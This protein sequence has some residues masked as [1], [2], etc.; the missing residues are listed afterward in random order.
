MKTIADE[1]REEGIQQGMQQGMQQE[2]R[3]MVLEAIDEQFGVLPSD[4][5]EGVNS[6]NNRDTLKSLFRQ[7]LHCK[8]INTF[9]DILRKVIG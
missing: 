2:A 4:I 3:D 8:D 6:I 9:R 7:V 5:A 1:I